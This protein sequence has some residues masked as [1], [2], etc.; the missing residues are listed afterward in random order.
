M[1]NTVVEAEHGFQVDLLEIKVIKGNELTDLITE[2]MDGMDFAKNEYDS[3]ML[4]LGTAGTYTAK[5]KTPGSIRG[6]EA[7]KEVRVSKQIA[8]LGARGDYIDFKLHVTGLGTEDNAHCIDMFK[9]QALDYSGVPVAV[10]HSIFGK[11]SPFLTPTQPVSRGMIRGVDR[12]EIELAWN[13]IL[14]ATETT[15]VSQK[16]RGTATSK[17]QVKSDNATEASITYFIVRAKPGSDQ[18]YVIPRGAKVWAGN[19]REAT[20]VYTSAV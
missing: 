11:Y 9:V 12:Q 2:T 16:I 3:P 6:W 17:L 19:G 5:V 18:V 10:Q 14:G 13:V 4:V 20:K 15:F 8:A 7:G 1:A